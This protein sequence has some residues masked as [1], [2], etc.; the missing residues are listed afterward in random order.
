MNRTLIE[1]TSQAARRL[2]LA[3]MIVLSCIAIARAQNDICLTNIGGLGGTPQVDGIVEGFTLGSANVDP[4]WNNAVRFNLSG[5]NGSTTATKLMAGRTNS[6]V[7]LAVVV[8]WSSLTA[9]QADTIVI[10]LS[11][12]ANAAEDWRIHI[13]PFD[14]G[15]TDGSN[16]V[17][18]GYLLEKQHRLEQCRQ[19]QPGC[20]CAWIL[21][22]G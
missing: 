2:M 3:A 4:G 12:T 14:T 22:E 17:P 7:Y 19:R 6:F 21:D 20:H 11:T 10:T 18:A 8:N 9:N 16:I 1:Q 13:K 15:I 5:D